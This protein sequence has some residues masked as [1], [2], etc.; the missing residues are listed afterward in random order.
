MSIEQQKPFAL[1]Y[2]GVSMRAGAYR[3]DIV[4]E[5]LVV[6]EVKAV[7]RLHPVHRSQM[8]C[9]LRLT[10]SRVGLILNFNVKLLAREGIMRVVN[11][12]PDEA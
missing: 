10:N 2:E 4:V 6:V 11:N 5:R 1:T 12:F 3:A 9:Y 7:E 8:I